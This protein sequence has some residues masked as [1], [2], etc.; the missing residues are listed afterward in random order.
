MNPFCRQDREPLQL[1]VLKLWELEAGGNALFNSLRPSDRMALCQMWRDGLTDLRSK[2]GEAMA[3]AQKKK[4]ESEEKDWEKNKLMG[5]RRRLLEDLL[6]EG[7]RE[8]M[9]ALIVPGHSSHRR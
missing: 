3:L 2:R 1:D 7:G 8:A 6:A 4:K 5:E 9:L